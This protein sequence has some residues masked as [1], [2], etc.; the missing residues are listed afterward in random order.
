M[1]ELNRVRSAVP[2]SGTC[3]FEVR[4]NVS[5]YPSPDG[6]R[7][8]IVRLKRLYNSCKN[9]N[10][11]NDDE[12]YDN[13]NNDNDVATT[14][15]TVIIKIKDPAIRLDLLGIEATRPELLLL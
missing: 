13:S 3:S 11:D 2:R 12:D 1:C 7:H 8:I 9:D 15:A 14:T 10:D 4:D 6:R 5:V